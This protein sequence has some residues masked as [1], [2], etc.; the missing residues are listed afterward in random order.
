[1]KFEMILPTCKYTECFANRG[2]ACNCLKENDWPKDKL[3]PFYKTKEQHRQDQ[4]SAERRLIK[5]YGTKKV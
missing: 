2:G 5:I 3:C 1:M 4:I